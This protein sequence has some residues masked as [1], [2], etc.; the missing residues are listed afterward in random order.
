MFCLINNE[1][2]T[3]LVG[4]LGKP[5]TE[6]GRSSH[7]SAPNTLERITTAAGPSASSDAL[8]RRFLHSEPLGD[9]MY[10]HL[11]EII[12]RGQLSA[13][14]QP[15]VNLRNGVIKGYE[16]LIRGPSDSPLHSPQSLFKSAAQYQLEAKLEYL[17]RRVVLEKFAE[18]ELEGQLFLNVSPECLIHGSAR[19]GETLQYMKEIGISP[20]QVIIELT[21]GQPTFDYDVLREAS[22]HYRNMGFQ[23]A[24][25]DLGEGFSGLRLWSELR[26]EFVKIDKHFIQGINHDPVKLQFVRSIHEIAAKSGCEVIAEGIETQAEFLVIRDLN[27]AFGQGYH[28]A[29]PNAKPATVLPAEVI[30]ALKPTAP[31]R[32]SSKQTHNV[33]VAI[34][35]MRQVPAVRSDTLN[36]IVYEKFVEA[37]E[38]Q[39]IPV[40]EN[41]KP[42]GMISRFMLIDRFARPY[43]RELYG[44]KSC[45]ELMDPAPLVVDGYTSI[46]E[47]GAIMIGAEHHH[48]ANGFIITENDLY[49]GIGTG[50]DLMRAITDMQLSAARHANPLTQLPGNILI[51]DQIEQLLTSKTPFYV[52]YCDM[53]Y[54]KPFNDVYG[55]HKGDEIIRMTGDLLGEFCDPIHDFIGHLGGDDFIILF[56]SPDWEE[57]CQNILA[58]FSEYVT[59]FFSPEDRECGVYFTEDR[60]GKRIFHP[61]TTLSLGVVEVKPDSYA[62]VHQVAAA[63]ADAKKQ[64]KKMFGNALFVERRRHDM[65]SS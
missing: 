37:P 43:Q 64:A 6:T 59:H 14:F 8:S 57:R 35:L 45:E 63:A 18:L 53:N 2:E 3:D 4:G 26:P 30:L 1:A 31:Q 38:L 39:A 40:V 28:L 44:K 46:R 7:P 51:D 23:I 25:D 33:P 47:L 61:L 12:E 9:G 16:G 52:C 27:I 49:L 54:F 41:G 19:H 42:V 60:Q 10:A 21:E 22:R 13:L 17:C 62:T 65:S 48:L 5:K 50:H 56:Q 36:E 58:L 32:P 55:F 11:C 24:M 15:V 29:R 34:N 20:T